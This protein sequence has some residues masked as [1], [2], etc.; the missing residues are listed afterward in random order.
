MQWM[1][2][3]GNE[4]GGPG[5][6]DDIMRARGIGI[7]LKSISVRYRRPVTYPD[8]VR[9]LPLTPS[10]MKHIKLKRLS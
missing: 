6:V 7:I 8:T 1:T 4:I 10:L 3:V 5:I 9:P 2:S